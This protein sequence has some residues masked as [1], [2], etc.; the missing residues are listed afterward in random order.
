M[1][2]WLSEFQKEYPRVVIREPKN[3]FYKKFGIRVSVMVPKNL[4]PML[5]LGLQNKIADIFPK[6]SIK[7]RRE[8]RKLN[9]FL[10]NIEDFKNLVDYLKTQASHVP[11][12]GFKTLDHHI[13]EVQHNSL[14]IVRGQ[15][16][17]TKIKS[18]GFNYR[19]SINRKEPF[20]VQEKTRLLTKLKEDPD[21]Y[22][23]PDSVL[24]WLASPQH[25][26]WYHRY[27]YVR[28]P[29]TVTFL[30]LSCGTLLDEVVEVLG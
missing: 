13:C 27:F 23:I 26:C 22:R 1:D 4:N 15:I 24:R 7:Q 6:D 19:L 20:T 8:H 11:N 18:L 5:L 9:I 30:Q 10:S 14:N 12:V 28:D 17:S 2:S 29:H 16:R 3:L 25:R 21:Q